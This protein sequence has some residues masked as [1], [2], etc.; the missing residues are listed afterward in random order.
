MFDWE[1]L[2]EINHI[3]EQ[4][5]ATSGTNDK[6]SILFANKDHILLSKVL[7]YTYDSRLKYGI[8]KKNL[9]S[10][11]SQKGSMM[12]SDPFKMLDVLAESNINNDLLASVKYY[13]Y[14][15]VPEDLQELV[16]MII[17]KDLKIKINATTINKVFP[18]LIYQFK[19][20]L[21]ESIDKGNLNNGEEIYVTRKLNGTR[22]IYFDNK[23]YARSGKEIEGFQNIKDEIKE[24]SIGGITLDGELVKINKKSNRIDDEENFK[25]SISIINSKK[26]ST[27][28]ENQIEYVLFDILN[29]SEFI[30]GKSKSLYSERR[31]KLDKLRIRIKELQLKHI[32]VTPILYHGVYSKTKI[33][34]MLEISDS[35]N[36]EGLMVN[37]NAPYECRRVKTLLKV[38]SWKFNDLKIIGFEQG[39]GEFSNT[40]GAVIVDY[41]GYPCG[42]GTGFDVETRNWIWQHKDELIGRICTIKCKQESCNKFGELSMNFPV[43]QG[44]RE[45]GKEVSYES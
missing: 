19:L 6:I 10:K 45:E 44:L 37:L 14:Q 20:Q 38:K 3:I 1:E 15:N 18:N 21:G 26:R 16:K 30:Q 13:L 22:A 31:K 34:K 29:T 35:R 40:L 5:R 7:Y 17:L 23:L 33:D 8:Q 27:E 4:L 39:E 9:T 11:T 36:Y 2:R 41:K 12:F 28:Q 43:W 42:V 25:Q 24:L 32:R